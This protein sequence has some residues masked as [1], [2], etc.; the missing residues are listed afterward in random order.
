M[1]C[2]IVEEQ[3]F[4]VTRSRLRLQQSREQL[5]TLEGTVAPSSKV[6]VEACDRYC[7]AKGNAGDYSFTCDKRKIV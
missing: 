6:G 2:V 5:E 4:S 1:G 3:S 7:G